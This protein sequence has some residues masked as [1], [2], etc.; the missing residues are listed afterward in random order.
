MEDYQHNS[1]RFL[2]A[3]RIFRRLKREKKLNRKQKKE[4]EK[5]LR[6]MSYWLLLNTPQNKNNPAILQGRINLC[7][8]DLKK[9]NARS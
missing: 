9:F 5:K 6:V 7:L 2:F 4:I 8:S 3:C 1:D